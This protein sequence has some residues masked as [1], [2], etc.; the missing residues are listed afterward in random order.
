MVDRLEGSP[1]SLAGAMQSDG[2]GG[3]TAAEDLSA[4]CSWQVV[5]LGQTEDFLILWS[6]HC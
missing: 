5:P 1:E 6:E 4:L 2:E 3:S